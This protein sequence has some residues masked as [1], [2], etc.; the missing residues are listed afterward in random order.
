MKRKLLISCMSF[1][2]IALLSASPAAAL[3][4]VN[5]NV[6]DLGTGTF[7]YSYEL[8]NPSDSTENIYDFG[9][10]FQGTPD[11]VI[12]P[13]GWDAIFGLGFIDWFSV[14]PANDLLVGSTLGGFSFESTLPPGAIEFT[15]L[16]YSALTGEVGVPET[17]ATTG[18][19]SAVPE[20]GSLW[21]LGM[22]LGT[23]LVQKRRSRRHS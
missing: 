11:N 7:R 19:T 6:V 17:G 14:D 21:L 22:G 23:W 12:A 4:I 10:Y 13:T 16:G 18:P 9:I 1:G 2:L 3:P 8:S 5:T 15:S 20:P